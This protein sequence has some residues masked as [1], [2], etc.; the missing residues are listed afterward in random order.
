MELQ[1]GDIIRIIS[2]TNKDY[3]NNEF[4]IDYI[5][6]KIIVIIND[7]DTYELTIEDGA[8]TDESIQSID[9]LSRSKYDSYVRQNGIETGDYISV[10]FSGKKPYILNGNVTNIDEDM[11]EISRDG[12]DEKFYID[13]AYQGVPRNLNIERI[14][15]KKEEEEKEKE[16]EK[17]KEE[18][19][20]EEF[21]E[22]IEKK[23]G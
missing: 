8:F 17:E 12:D 20:K 19:E 14:I 13:F 4:F 18:E 3:H 11:I 7:K 10:Y 1:L 15:V 6:E 23:D 9:I 21:D 2:P 16:K 22:G 5:D